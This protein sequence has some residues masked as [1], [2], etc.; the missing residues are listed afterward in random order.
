MFVIGSPY[1]RREREKRDRDG[2][3]CLVK[4]ERIPERQ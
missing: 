2:L 3:E 4:K 1:P